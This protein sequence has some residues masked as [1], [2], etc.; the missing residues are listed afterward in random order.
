MPIAA[1]YPGF[2]ECNI[3]QDEG[4][5]TL[6]HSRLMISLCKDGLLR[7]SLRRRRW[8]WDK[9][10]I[11]CQKLP[12]DVAE[13]MSHT[14]EAL[15]DDVKETLRIL[16][17]FGASVSNSFVSTLE[18]AINKPLLDSIDAAV[19]EGLLDNI[20][21]QYRFSHDRIQEAAYRMN[22]IRDQGRSHF[23]YG[24]ALAP[25]ADEEDDLLFTAVTQ[26]NLAGPEA[27]EDERQYAIVAKHNL[28]AGKKAMEMSDFEAA[29]SYFDHGMTFLRKKHWE[30]HYALSLELFDLAAECALTNGDIVSLNILSEQV[31][32]KGRS[33]E[34]KLNVMY[35]VTCSLVSS[36]KIPD[37]LEWDLMFCRSWVLN[38]NWERTEQ[39]KM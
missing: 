37:Q 14:I 10:K 29:Y 31:I 26:L 17:C 4:K 16:S 33:Y 36:F 2:V 13:F 32:A 7:P 11:L 27:V 18:R 34:D 20:D 19:T 38:L 22:D 6:R 5:S 21:D 30:E 23:S 8:E 39:M 12:D 28:R 24:M 1:S 25:L 9:E 3:P 35:F 15:P